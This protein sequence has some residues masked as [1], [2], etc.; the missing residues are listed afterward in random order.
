ML[1]QGKRLR[2]KRKKERG[3]DTET[4]ACNVGSYLNR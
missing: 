3:K 1:V 4:L 2:L